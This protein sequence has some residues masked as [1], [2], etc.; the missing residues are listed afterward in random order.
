MN[1]PYSPLRRYPFHRPRSLCDKSASIHPLLPQQI[2]SIRG[3]RSIQG[4]LCLS[5][6]R[7]K[8]ETSNNGFFMVRTPVEKAFTIRRPRLPKSRPSPVRNCD[9]G[10][11]FLRNR[12]FISR[13]CHKPPIA[14]KMLLQNFVSATNL[15]HS[16]LRD[17]AIVEGL[18]L[19][20]TCV[21]SKDVI[22]WLQLIY[23][24]MTSIYIEC[25]SIRLNS[26]IF[27]GYVSILKKRKYSSATI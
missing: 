26:S 25:K 15:V 4:I 2:V 13:E 27:V 6:M 16:C 8:R 22:P 9:S 5:A 14:L 1:A 24:S 11:V 23:I 18:D 7:L 3:I 19:R 10:Q 21:L 20:H 17:V 12:D